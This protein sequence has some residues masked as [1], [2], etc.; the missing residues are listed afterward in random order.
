MNATQTPDQKY[1]SLRSFLEDRAARQ[2]NPMSTKAQVARAATTLQ[3]ALMA[4]E[5]A[6]EADGFF[7]AHAEQSTSQHAQ[8]RTRATAH[9]AAYDQRQKKASAARL[10][11]ATRRANLAGKTYRHAVATLTH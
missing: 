8:L 7:V 6:A 10:A 5:E 9:H 1:T 11:A 3:S 4:Y 2:G